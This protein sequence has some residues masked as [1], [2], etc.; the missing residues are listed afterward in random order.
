MALPSTSRVN[1][2]LDAY[3]SA[4][5]RWLIRLER[6]GEEGASNR[7]SPDKW[8]SD[9]VATWSD[10]WSLWYVPYKICDE[11]E[12]NVQFEI[13]TT[14]D[15]AIEGILVPDPG[16][17]A[18]TWTPI[19]KSGGPSI[20]V[21]NIECRLIQERRTLVVRLFGLQGL[22]TKLTPG[23]YS[24]TVAPTAAPSQRL[25]QIIVQVK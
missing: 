20:P 19:S 10:A 14:T 23:D 25:A 18:L 16:S 12:R 2:I 24:G 1:R 22:A 13:S 15:Q 9:V 7:Y 11:R 8:L 4:W 21:A 17:D 3:G 6:A 5:E